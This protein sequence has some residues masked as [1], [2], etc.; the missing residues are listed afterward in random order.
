MT[1]ISAALVKE[2]REST[3]V[4]MMDCKRALQETNG[5][6]D[7]AVTL[8][9]ER[10]LAKQAQRAG[11]ATTE[12]LVG[13]RLAEDNKQGTIV[14]VGCETEPVSKNE[15]FQ[16]F[17]KKVLETVEAGGAGVAAELDEERNMVVRRLEDRRRARRDQCGAGRSAGAMP[18]FDSSPLRLTS[19]SAGMPSLAA[20][21]SES[22]E[23]Q[24]SQRALTTFALRLCRCPMKCQRNVSP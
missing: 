16:A 1:E 5:D 13:Y 3:G 17:A 20:A 14:A 21:D 7:A 23:W 18:D 9:R 15:E 11:R 19:T 24:S 10:G 12:G 6:M 4:G 22:S 2:L 8:L